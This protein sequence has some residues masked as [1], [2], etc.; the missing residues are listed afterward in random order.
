MRNSFRKSTSD[1]LPEVQSLA[2]E[3]GELRKVYTISKQDSSLFGVG[4]LCI[5]CSVLWMLFAALFAQKS[6]TY[7]SSLEWFILGLIF[8]IAGCYVTLSRRIYAH[9]HISLWQYGFLYE[10]G[11]MRQVFRWDQIDT[12]H[13]MT[14]PL[15]PQIS[16]CDVC[17]RDGYKVLLRSTLSTDFRELIDMVFEEVLLQFAPQELS[18]APPEAISTLTDVKIDQQGIGNVQEMLAWQEIQEVMIKNGTV[19]LRK[20]TE[21]QISSHLSCGTI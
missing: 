1:L 12:I 9:W 2:E 3:L 10:K 18:I 11:Q 21:E 4:I 20:K 13:R 5:V 19:T 14:N 7:P 16:F 6:S 17:R 15:N 8:L